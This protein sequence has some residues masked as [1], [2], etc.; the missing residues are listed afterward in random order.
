MVGVRFIGRLGN[1]MFQRSAVI[2]YARK[3]NVGY[4]FSQDMDYP[5][6]KE[7]CFEYTEIPYFNNV[8]L[9]GYFQSEKYF[10]HCKEEIID[11]FT[12]DWNRTPINKISIHVRRGDYCNIECHPVVTIEYLNEAIQIFKDK[13]YTDKDFLVFTD[14]KTWCRDNLPYEIAEGNELEDLELMSRCEHHIISNSS[15]SYWGAYLGVNK[16]K[17]VI[18]PKL[19]FA[20][21]KKDINVSDLYCQ[22]WIV[23]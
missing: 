15:F 10:N 5:I 16:S 22:G 23:I 21:S 19:W 8:K 2:G 11:Y 12:K 18:A 13:G 17:V 20:G 9:S 7:K 3:Y 6:Y 4:T 1:N 14:D